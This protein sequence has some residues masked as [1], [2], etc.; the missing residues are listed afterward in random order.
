MRVNRIL[1]VIMLFQLTFLTHAQPKVNEQ[2]NGFFT[3]P[4]FAGDYPDPSILRDGDDYYIVHSSFEYY[5][6]LLIWHSKDLIN[7]EPLTNALHTY[8][9]SV[10]APDLVKHGGKYYIYFPVNY[11][12]YVVWANSINGPWSEPI[13]LKVGHIDPG[14][15]VDENGKR[16]LFFSSGGFVP[17]SD[18]G[19]SVAGEFKSSYS[20]WPIPR[21]W[22][23]ECFCMEGPKLIKRGDYYYLTV[24]QGGTAGPATG[25][26]VISAR[27][28]SLFGPWENSPY[29]PI[30]R[31]TDKS[32][33]WWSKGHST[34]FDDTEG[35]WWMVYHAY[36]K[37]YLN[38]GRQT[39]LLP[40]EWTNDSWYR[41]PKDV[42]DTKPVKKEGFTAINTN[43][44]FT[45]HFEGNELKPQWKFFGEYDTNRFCVEDNSLIL[46]AK[47]NSIGESSPLL[48][49]P[50][51]H[52]YTAAVELHIEGKATGGLVLFYNDRA[53]SGILAD[54]ENILANINGWQFETEKNVINNRVYL[55]LKNIENTVNLYYSKDGTNWLKIENSLEISGFNHN[56]FGGFLAVRIG[57]SA[58]G[59]GTVTFKNFKVSN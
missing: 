4:V 36:E 55:R 16:Y 52:S 43:S 38:L 14:H 56:A 11:S 53:H 22:S 23:I 48:F 33:R 42:S 49:T 54:N 20:G 15:V 59:E 19:L 58:F 32:E 6:G 35:N 31:T 34:I 13:E 37:G 57:L 44:T 3:N 46:T 2:S 17:L 39:L 7:W 8:L 50:T 18:D 30:A 29:N 12:N 26:M 40:V 51:G 28:K 45:D 24:A 9:G 1:L 21:E 27:S 25:H 5:P 47:G 10:W 41:V